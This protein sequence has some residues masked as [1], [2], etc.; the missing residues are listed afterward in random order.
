MLDCSIRI[1]C[2]ILIVLIEGL[3]F[4]CLPEASKE[5]LDSPLP[6]IIA[7][8]YLIITGMLMF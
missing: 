3:S 1:I 8:Q 7:F 2:D 4:N 5:G 6:I